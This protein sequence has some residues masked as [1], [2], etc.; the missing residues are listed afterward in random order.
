MNFRIVILL[1]ILLLNACKQNE[2]RNN[3]FG[4]YVNV[5]EPA[6]THYVELKEDSTYL[7]YYKKASDSSKI[8]QGFWYF[9]KTRGETQIVF[10]NWF[11]YGYN[12]GDCNGCINYALLIEGELFFNLDV[13]IEMNFKKV[14]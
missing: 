3:A 12:A 7:H 9:E 6:T 5:Y 10:S 2:S 14:E 1:M 13:P 4:K 11:T 8:N